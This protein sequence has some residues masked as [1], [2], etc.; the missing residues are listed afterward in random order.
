MGARAG[1][2]HPLVP[3]GAHSGGILIGLADGSVRFLSVGAATARLGP[4]PLAGALA[5]YD[6]PAVGSTGPAQVTNRG[7]VWSALLS[8]DGGETFTLD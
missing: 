3:S 5:A 2:C 4:A 7:Y 6:Q 8:P 1:A